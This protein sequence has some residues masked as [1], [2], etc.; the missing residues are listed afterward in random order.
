MEKY[1]KTKVKKELQTKL[2]LPKL[3]MNR[4]AIEESP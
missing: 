1:L 4:K 3:F 2:F